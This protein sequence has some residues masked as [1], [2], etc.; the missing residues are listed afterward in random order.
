MKSTL[1]NAIKYGNTQPATEHII[2]PATEHIILPRETI[3]STLQT[4]EFCTSRQENHLT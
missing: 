1:L 4:F 2:L 3:N